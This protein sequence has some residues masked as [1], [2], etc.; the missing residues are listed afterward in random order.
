[1]S[2]GDFMYVD[3]SRLIIPEGKH[4]C[5]WALQSMMPVFAAMQR[6]DGQGDDW[7][8][9]SNIFVRTDPDGLVHF[10]IERTD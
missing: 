7:I 5:M 8:G 4:M 3:G 2:L 10:R 9:K 6:A 1:M